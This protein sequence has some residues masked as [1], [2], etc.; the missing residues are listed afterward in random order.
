MLVLGKDAGVPVQVQVQA[1]GAD[2]GNERCGMDGSGR[3][4]MDE[5]KSVA[6]TCYDCVWTGDVLRNGLVRAC[7]SSFGKDHVMP[8][9]TSWGPKM[10]PR[11]AYDHDWPG[12]SLDGLG[13]MQD[14]LFAM[15]SVINLILKG[16]RQ[17]WR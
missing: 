2:A 6:G 4:R 17:R 16:G 10:L 8:L 15:A 7:V 9:P 5:K 13:A 1:Q 11:K 12:R 14:S 3:G